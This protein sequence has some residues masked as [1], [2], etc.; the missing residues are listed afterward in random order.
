MSCHRPAL[1]GPL[2][3][4]RISRSVI[5]LIYVQKMQLLQRYLIRFG[6]VLMAG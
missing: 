3:T 4:A 1:I 5:D 2:A 6:R